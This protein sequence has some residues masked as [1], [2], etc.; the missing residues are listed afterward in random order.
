M[1]K[2]ARLVRSRRFWIVARSE[3]STGPTPGMVVNCL[4]GLSALTTLRSP[5][6]ALRSPRRAAIWQSSGPADAIGVDVLAILVEAVAR[7]ALQIIGVLPALRHDVADLGEMPAQRFAR[8]CAG[9]RAAR[10]PM[11]RKLGLVV[12]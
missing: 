1:L 9:G 7:Y 4:A 5:R 11:A 8:P 3:R 2:I 12:D 10:R 6:R